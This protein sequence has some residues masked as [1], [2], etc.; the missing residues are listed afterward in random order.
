MDGRLVNADQCLTEDITQF[1]DNVARL[2]SDLT[3]P[4]LDIFLITVT[5]VQAAVSRG[6]KTVNTRQQ[7]SHDL[8]FKILSP[9]LLA[10]GVI[11]FTARILRM[12]SPRFGDIVAEE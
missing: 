3:K 10:V 4:I 8:L 11:I 1:A 2:Y 12:V 9:S 6:S 5:L 7:Y